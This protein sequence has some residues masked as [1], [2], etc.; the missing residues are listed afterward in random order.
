MTHCPKTFD[1]VLSQLSF[2]CSEAVTARFA[3][4]LQRPL[5]FREM[6]MIRSPHKADDLSKLPR[7]RDDASALLSR[8]T[9]GLGHWTLRSRPHKQSTL[10]LR[11]ATSS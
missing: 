1:N 8:L 6:Y 5:E 4:R 2:I 9:L 10:L 11:F 7:V 3:S